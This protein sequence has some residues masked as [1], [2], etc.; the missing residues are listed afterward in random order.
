[1]SQ[2]NNRQ[3]Q[4]NKN[5]TWPGTQQNSGFPFGPYAREYGT[6]LGM[7]W[8]LQ[9]F[10]VMRALS[11]LTGATG[12][13]QCALLSILSVLTGVGSLVLACYLGRRLRTKLPER[14]SLSYGR[15]YVFVFVMMVYAALLQAAF[16]YVYM[17]FVDHGTILQNL[18]SFVNDPQVAAQMR[19]AGM[20][21][22]LAEYRQNLHLLGLAPLW[23]IALSTFNQT[24]MGS[25]VFALAVAAF[26]R[27]KAVG[28]PA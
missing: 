22:M 9:A 28:T 15:A 8:I 4:Q 27:K 20:G 18:Q 3:S 6:F 17:Q 11:V 1:M 19:G 16:V 5:N 7:V 21:P 13:G 26:A 24:I 12:A 14:A 23:Q 25:L 2:D 10:L